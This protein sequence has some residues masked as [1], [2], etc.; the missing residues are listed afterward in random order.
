[1]RDAIRNVMTRVLPEPAP[2]RI[3]SGPSRGRTAPRCSGLSRFRKSIVREE[4]QYNSRGSWLVARGS[5][6]VRL[7]DDREAC[8]SPYLER[9]YQ[10]MEQLA[11]SRQL[12]FGNRH[13]RV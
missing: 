1:M 4:L 6:V 2:A 9:A 5:W 12:L 7:P 3:R 13:V 11:S 8:G 10:S